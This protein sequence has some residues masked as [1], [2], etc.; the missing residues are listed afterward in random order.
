[1]ALMVESNT[2][3]PC[4]T[5]RATGEDDWERRAKYGGRFPK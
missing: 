3:V 5:G 4:P 2:D 1:L